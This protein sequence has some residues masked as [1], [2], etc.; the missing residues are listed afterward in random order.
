V[1]CDSS[2]RRYAIT[3][4]VASSELMEI[5]HYDELQIQVFEKEGGK[6]EVSSRAFNGGHANNRQLT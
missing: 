5:D 1:H 3:D 6:I 2:A 4:A